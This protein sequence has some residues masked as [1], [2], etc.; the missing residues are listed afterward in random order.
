M[1]GAPDV[2]QAEERESSNSLQWEPTEVAP[3]LTT[4]GNSPSVKGTEMALPHS[5]RGNL[6]EA[7]AGSSCHCCHR[8]PGWCQGPIFQEHEPASFEVRCCPWS[9]SCGLCFSPSGHDWPRAD[10]GGV[11]C[12]P[13]CLPVSHRR[14]SALCGHR[15]PQEP[16]G[17]PAVRLLWRRPLGKLCACAALAPRHTWGRS[18]SSPEKQKARK[19]RAGCCCKGRDPGG[20]CDFSSEKGITFQR[21]PSPGCPELHGS[22]QRLPQIYFLWTRV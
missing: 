11:L 10:L 17:S 3:T 18:A 7:S 22:P 20:S 15:R 5:P 8:K 13:A 4:K 19:A 16:R 21:F 9:H 14:S 2:L 6:G 12:S 1:S